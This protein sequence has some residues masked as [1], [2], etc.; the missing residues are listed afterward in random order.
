MAPN[1]KKI[2]WVGHSFHV[3]L[4]SPVASLAKEAG[5]KGHENLGTD[6]LPASVPC[7]HWNKGGAWKD[8]IQAG[9]A[10]VLTIATREDAPDPCV[11]KFVKLAAAKRPDMQVM[12][13]E[14]WLPWSPNVQEGLN[15][16]DLDQVRTWI[17]SPAKNVEKCA[18]FAG[19]TARDSATV[20]TLERT[21][22]ELEGPYRERLRKQLAEINKEMGKNFTVLVPVWDAVITLRQMI[23]DGKVPGVSKQSELFQDGL[24]HA[25]KPLQDLASYVW[26]GAIYNQTPVGL[27]ALGGA[28]GQAEVLQKIAWE[29]LKKEPLSGVH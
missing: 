16:L 24:G 9:K 28:A 14:T 5:I 7:Q 21:R 18:G 22:T 11:P 29:A 10:D 12:I 6:F 15:Y 3:F 20:K 23:V 17:N 2:Q 26:F 4:P 27:K 19:C 13:Q 1:G 25:R 8:V